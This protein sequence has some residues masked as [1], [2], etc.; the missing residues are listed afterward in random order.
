MTTRKASTAVNVPEHIEPKKAP[1]STRIKVQNFSDYNIDD[2]HV[3]FDEMIDAT[4]YI[5]KLELLTGTQFGDGFRVHFKDLPNA[6]D[7]QTASCFGVG[8][9]PQLK[10]LYN[11]THDG[12]LISLTSP[13]KAKIIQA[14]RS[15]KFA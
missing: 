10:S 5:V 8:I 11:L 12:K 2:A 15:Y 3:R 14:G 7:T 9:T 6:A 1:R 4:I 13:I